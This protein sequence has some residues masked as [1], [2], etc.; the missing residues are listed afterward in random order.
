MRGNGRRIYRP[1]TGRLGYEACVRR[2][3]RYLIPPHGRHCAAGRRYAD[4]VPV[5]AL[6]GQVERK[7]TG[8]DAK[9][10]LDQQALIPPLAA[11]ITPP[12]P[13]LTAPPVPDPAVIQGALQLME[14]ATRPLIP[15]GQGARLAG[16]DILSLAERWGAGII[17]SLSA[18]GSVPF[19][20]P[21]VL[22]GLGDGGTSASHTALSEADLLLALGCNWWPTRYVPGA[23]PV[24]K[25]DRDPVNIGGRMSV[26]YR[27]PGL[28]VR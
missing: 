11:P 28:T 24:I 20:H 9:Q 12:K 18:K 6:T 2:R 27:L 14:N 8:S 3:G 19:S 10:Y 21:L 13:Y 23:L 5:L 25:V 7:K 15:I 22:G 26:R 1:A 17:Q 4:R 16:G